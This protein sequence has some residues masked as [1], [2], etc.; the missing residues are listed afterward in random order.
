MIDGIWHLIGIM[1]AIMLMILWMY[2]QDKN[3]ELYR[4]C[5][6]HNPDITKCEAP[7]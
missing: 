4:L 3:I 2:N 1:A 7:K 6:V 5:L